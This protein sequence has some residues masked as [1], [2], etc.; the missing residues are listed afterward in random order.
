MKRN[1]IYHNNEGKGRKI[2][3]YKRDRRGSI[4]PKGLE[5][6]EQHKTANKDKKIS[7]KAKQATGR[8]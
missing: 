5:I 4:N 7:P 6:I 8:R 2:N 3:N 1:G